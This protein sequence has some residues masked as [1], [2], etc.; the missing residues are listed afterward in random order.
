M[1]KY[2]ISFLNLVPSLASSLGGRIPA[3]ASAAAAAAEA[4]VAFRSSETEEEFSRRIA[5]KA[6]LYKLEVY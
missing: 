1:V 6:I 3:A 4:S 5:T 2:K